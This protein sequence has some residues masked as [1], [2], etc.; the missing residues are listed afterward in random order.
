MDELLFNDKFNKSYNK[1]EVIFFE[2]S[3]GRHMYVINSGTVNIVK[4]ISGRNEV[5][6]TLGKGS[7]FGEMALIDDMPR[8]ASVI[9]AEDGTSV[10]E[11]DHALFIYLVG[12]QPAFALVILKTLSMRFRA[13]MSS[14]VA[15]REKA[16]KE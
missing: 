16:G 7:I 4:K 14:T 6:A 3:V 13:Q 1:D 15:D 12:Q 9:V 8:S 2:G 5:I 11:I 10:L